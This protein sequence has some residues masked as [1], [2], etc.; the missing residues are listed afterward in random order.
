M[1]RIFIGHAYACS[2]AELDALKAG[3]TEAAR[4]KLGPGLPF[5]V[6]LGRDSFQQHAMEKGGWA[7]WSDYVAIGKHSIT[8][9]PCFNAIVIPYAGPHGAGV[10]GAATAQII[11]KAGEAGKAVRAFHHGSLF[12]VTG[13][14]DEDV[15]DKKR[16][17]RIL[18]PELDL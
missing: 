9:E 1:Y 17:W 11:S 14:V 3:V 18:V 13:I 10:V 6:T 12:N 8:H 16:G 15:T 2:S 7:Q 5:E 4:A